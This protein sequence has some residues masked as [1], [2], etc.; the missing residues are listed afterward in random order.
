MH[1][2]SVQWSN[3]HNYNG[4]RVEKP[5]EVQGVSVKEC[6][7]VWKSSFILWFFKMDF[8]A[9]LLVIR[10][11]HVVPESKAMDLR[12]I[13]PLFVKESRREGRKYLQHVSCSHDGT[14]LWGRKI[15]RWRP[16]WIQNKQI[17]RAGN[18]GE[19]KNT[20]L[21]L[22]TA[23][24]KKIKHYC[25]GKRIL[26]SWYQL[27]FIS[28]IILTDTLILSMSSQ[29]NQMCHFTHLPVTPPV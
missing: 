2:K 9:C 28:T 20:Y 19:S 16:A 18:T 15:M 10:R 1:V 21:S 3:Y 8:I 12:N 11:E 5:Q 22:M 7:L 29:S 27:N 26:L 24:I 23:G 14:C 13:F 25:P 4:N 17:S 6:H